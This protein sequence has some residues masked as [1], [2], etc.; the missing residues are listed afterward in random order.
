LERP[1]HSFLMIHTIVCYA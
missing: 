1:K